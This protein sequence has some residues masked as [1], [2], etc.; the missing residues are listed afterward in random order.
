[1]FRTLLVNLMS[2]RINSAILFALELNYGIACLDKL[3]FT[4][5][6]YYSHILSVL[7]FLATFI[8]HF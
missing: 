4:I 7:I 3:H 5:L 8:G 1:V 2:R 6:A